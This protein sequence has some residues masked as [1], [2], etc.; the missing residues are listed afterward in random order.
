[1]LGKGDGTKYIDEMVVKVEKLRK[2]CGFNVLVK[3]KVWK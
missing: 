3:P 2:L 1:M